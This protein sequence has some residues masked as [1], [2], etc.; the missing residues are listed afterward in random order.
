MVLIYDD[1][2][3]YFR[4]GYAEALAVVLF[5]AVVAFTLLIFWSARLWVYYEGGQRGA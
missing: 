1:A 4:M 2:F 3:G 5:L